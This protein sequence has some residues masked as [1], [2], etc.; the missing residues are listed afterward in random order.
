V[1]ALSGA[2]LIAG[3]QTPAAN[4]FAGD[5]NTRGGVPLAAIRADND[6]RADLLTGAGEGDPPVINTYLGAT[7]TP[8]GTPPVFR[9]FTVFDPSTRGGVFVGGS[10]DE[11]P[12]PI[13]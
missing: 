3:R 7:I 1:F 12:I 2:E 8:A 6:A 5:P 10:P 11:V 4:F 13:D 9:T